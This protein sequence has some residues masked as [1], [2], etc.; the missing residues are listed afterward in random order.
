[1]DE[2]GLR[3]GVGRGKWV[4]VP[5][6]QAKGAF[7]NLIG[8]KADS[9]HITVVEAVSASRATISPLII[10]KGVVIQKRWFTEIRDNHLA[11]ITL[12]L[13]YSNDVLSF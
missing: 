2:I 6:D 1:M 12:D 13:G 3:V 11:I 7:A 5:A 9:E 10:I 4:I 8:S